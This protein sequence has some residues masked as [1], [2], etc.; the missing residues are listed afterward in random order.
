[1]NTRLRA[2]NQSLKKQKPDKARIFARFYPA[3]AAAGYGL[4]AIPLPATQ[5]GV[6]A[7]RQPS[8]FLETVL[9]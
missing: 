4:P 7:S 3:V 5:T 1:M 8:G 2:S 9:S 6:H